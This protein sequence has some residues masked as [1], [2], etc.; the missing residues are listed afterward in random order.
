M[1]TER[2]RFDWSFLNF[3]NKSFWIGLLVGFASVVSFVAYHKELRPFVVNLHSIGVEEKAE[4]LGFFLEGYQKTLKE[5][6]RKFDDNVDKLLCFK[7]HMA[8]ALYLKQMAK[9][10]DEAFAMK[11]PNNLEW[12]LK[13]FL[14]E[15]QKEREKRENK[16]KI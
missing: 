13:N 12:R 8:T 4:Q 10:F 9:C 15:L 14:D 2:K 5:S 11:D 6:A 3:F 7:L 1:K 16:V